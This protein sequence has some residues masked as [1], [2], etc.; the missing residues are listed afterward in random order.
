MKFAS[1]ISLTLVAYIVHTCAAFFA[2]GY[3]CQQHLPA[4]IVYISP[5]LCTVRRNT[6]LS[7]DTRQPFC[8]RKYESTAVVVVSFL[9]LIAGVEPNPGSPS[10]G[11]ADRFLQFGLLN[12]RSAVRKAASIH[13]VI[14]D[15][16]LDVIAL[17]ESWMRSDDPDAIK[18]DIAPSD[19]SV[20][21]AFREV[22]EDTR[23]RG[24]GVALVYRSSL[25]ATLLP[26]D[27]YTQFELISIK[28]ESTGSPPI[29]IV[30]VYRPSSI[31]LTSKFYDELCDLFDTMLDDQRYVLCG[32]FNCMGP[33]RQTTDRPPDID[34]N[35][36]DVLSRYNMTQHVHCSTHDHGNLLDLIITHESHSELVSD[37]D[38]I[39]VNSSDHRLIK[40]KLGVPIHRA[41][42][43]SYTY[44]D[45]KHMNME[46]FRRSMFESQLFNSESA[47][48]S[49]DD[50]AKLFDDEV[51]CALDLH[52][53]LL[54]KTK[55]VGRH[56]NRW[57]SSEARAAKRLSRR[58]ERRF[59]HTLSVADKDLFTAAR[60]TAFD[61]VQ[62]SRADFLRHQVES[63]A[64]HP[65][66]LWKTTRSLLHS[67]DNRSDWNDSECM[68]MSTDFSNFFSDKLSR[69][70]AAISTALLIANPIIFHDRP[71]AGG[72]LP[73]LYPTTPAEV[74][75]LIFSMPAKSSPLDII[76]TSLIK[77]CADIFAPIISTLANLSFANGHF[78]TSFK[79]AQLLPLLKKQG[80]NKSE[81]SN[82]R[83]IS[84]LNTVSKLLERL[85]LSRLRPQLTG[86]SNFSKLQSAYRSGCSTE[87]A[88]LSI[89]DGLYQA[90]DNKET[91]VLVSLDLSAAFDTISHD[92]LLNRL[93]VEFGVRG[94]ALA[95]IKS[96]LSDRQQFVKI[97]RH[98]SRSVSYNL[99]VPQGSVLGPL[100]FVTY[101][102]P[103]GDIVTSAGLGFHQYADDTQIY[104]AM[105][106]ATVS[107]QLDVLSTTT[108]RLRYWF[109]SNGL[110]LNPDKSEALLVGTHQQRSAVATIKSVPVAGVVLPISSELK[111]LGVIMDSQLSFD[112]QV[113]AMCR[114]CNFHIR[115]LWHVRHLLSSQVARTVACSIVGSR[116]DYCNAVLYGAN[117]TTLSRLQ[118][119]QNSLA[120]VVLQVPRRTHALPLL[121]Q[122]HWLPVE[123][124]ITYKTALLTYKVHVQSSPAYLHSLLIGR[125]C[126]RTL[127]SSET[128][129]FVQPRVRTVIAGRS[130]RVAAPAVWN[131]LPPTVVTSTSVSVFKSR[132]KTHLFNIAFKQ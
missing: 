85:A 102:S 62:Q 110:M 44:R 126:P 49:V 59:R 99:G 104:F 74:E 106:P 98:R 55:R 17:T 8:P 116:L 54:R 13:D 39:F 69:I 52:A 30:C 57:L 90:I 11:A 60:K 113:S 93:D 23:R 130:F 3:E 7:L 12:S 64:D 45:I 20:L 111:S 42:V 87:T 127:R 131:S 58:L 89:L 16:K 80:L 117:K 35:L 1:L 15:H 84:N 21:H 63:A 22:E 129:K 51:A 53:S 124:R 96:Y 65:R 2:A 121:H 95:W 27:R 38:A 9:L 114:A 36:A 47:R 31:S 123:H 100:L 26:V 68:K 81:L 79:T 41:A 101:V 92:I 67:D 125:S 24:G 48:H 6:L 88:L 18:L 94:T 82:Y 109:L 71:L 77:S 14:A 5:S 37:V 28:I 128:P 72:I 25:K 73:S 46:A 34:M 108:E 56:D 43:V 19:Y 86:S 107:Q 70:S 29:V 91:A 83:P 120:R 61:L 78:P 33:V 112:G 76:P 132:L 50:Y 118:R 40:C 105:K 75:K 122:L 103:V 115:A 97:G 10:A 4:C 32:D 119:I 66:Q